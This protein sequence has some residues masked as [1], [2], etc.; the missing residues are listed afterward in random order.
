MNIVLRV[1]ALP[2]IF[3]MFAVIHV[4][5]TVKGTWFF[6]KYGGEFM[7]YLKD[8][9]PTIAKIYEQLKNEEQ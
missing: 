7:A 3:G 6:L 5:I 8:D 9:K 2:F 1:I 4:A